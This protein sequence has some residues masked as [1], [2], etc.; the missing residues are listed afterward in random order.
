MK[1]M[2]NNIG[3]LKK[4][5]HFVGT[6]KLKNVKMYEDFEETTPVDEGRGNSVKAA[7][8]SVWYDINIMHL[9][10]DEGYLNDNN[11]IADGVDYKDVNAFLEEDAGAKDFFDSN[12]SMNAWVVNTLDSVKETLNKLKY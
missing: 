11:E 10:F 12:E 2:E 7:I 6:K 1:N 3:K 8:D 5:K 9:L 4:S